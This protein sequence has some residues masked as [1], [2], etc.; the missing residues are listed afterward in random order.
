MYVQVGENLP[1]SPP[2]A[3]DAD[4]SLSLV[5][6]LYLFYTV[7]IYTSLQHHVDVI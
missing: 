5:L 7:T 3:S 1:P 2:L 4:S 6:V